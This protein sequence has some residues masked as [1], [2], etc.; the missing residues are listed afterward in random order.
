MRQKTE[1]VLIAVIIAL[2]ILIITQTACMQCELEKLTRS[3][4]CEVR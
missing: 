3:S 1:V 4:V 2:A